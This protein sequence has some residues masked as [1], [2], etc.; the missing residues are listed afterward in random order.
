MGDKRKNIRYHT[1]AKARIEGMHE[2]EL[3]LKDISVLGCRVEWT[4]QAGIEINNTYKLE[5]I[6][7]NASKIGSFDFLAKSIWMRPG[8]YTC[9]IGFSIIESP[10]GRNFQRY[11]DYL[12][13]RF[14]HGDSI[15]GNPESP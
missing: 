2:G 1:L 4:A 8:N 13:W 7:E 15:G 12:S 5:V 11:V 9:E 10:R 6:P 3:L 14:N